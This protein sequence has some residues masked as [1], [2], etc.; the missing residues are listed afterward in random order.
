M[1]SSFVFRVSICAVAL[2]A[3]SLPAPLIAADCPTGRDLVTGIRAEYADGGTIEFRAGSD[4]QIVIF[5]PDDPGGS[6]GLVFVSQAGLYDL[7]AVPRTDGR[8]D[9]DSVLVMTYSALPEDL[10][11]PQPGRSWLGNVRTT[12]PD[13]ESDT[14]TAVYVFGNGGDRTIGGCSYATIP[15]KASFIG[16][17][18]WVAQHFIYFTD[19][20]IAVPSARIDS[21]DETIRGRAL[22]G[23][24]AIDG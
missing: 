4:G 22:A 8:D 15:I 13:G 2:S 1:A 3:A 14:H 5:E 9:R 18:E 19:L 17:V 6:S 12:Y 23:L 7:L 24:A 21:D 11:H 10:P 16:P 20:G